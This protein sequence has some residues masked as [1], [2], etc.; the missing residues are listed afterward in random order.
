MFFCNYLEP[1]STQFRWGVGWWT[2]SPLCSLEGGDTAE[3]GMVISVQLN[4]NRL[5][6]AARAKVLL[7]FKFKE[8]DWSLYKQNDM[9]CEHS[10]DRLS[11]IIINI[12]GQ[13]ENRPV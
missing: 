11:Q 10:V 6:A 1:L 8:F 4:D 3:Q 13:I 7:L 2:E 12:H 9:T 5:F